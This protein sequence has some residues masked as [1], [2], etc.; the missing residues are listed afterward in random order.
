MLRPL[1]P[2]PVEWLPEETAHLARKLCQNRVWFAE[3]EN[4]EPHELNPDDGCG[5]AKFKLTTVHVYHA[6]RKELQARHFNETANYY[7]DALEELRSQTGSILKLPSCI[8]RMMIWSNFQQK[9]DLL[10]EPDYALM[11]ML[12]RNLYKTR[13]RF[14]EVKFGDL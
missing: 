7:R 14:E 5:G 13:P 9:T 4:G 10:E 3:D 11:G 6:P 8:S 12:W 1:V 2:C